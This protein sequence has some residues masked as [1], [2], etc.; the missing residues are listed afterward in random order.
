MLEV[1]P[2]VIQVAASGPDWPAIVA[3]ISTGV[4]AVAGI[5][6]ALWQA[7]HNWDHDDKRAKLSEKRRIYA[8]FLLTLNE[9]LRAAMEQKVTKGGRGSSEA[10][11]KYN[12]AHSRCRSALFELTLI[13]PAGVRDAAIYALSA[14]GKYSEDSAA[15]AKAVAELAN[16]MRVDLG[17]PP[18]SPIPMASN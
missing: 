4:A 10:Q 16:E 6:A 1:A 3:S 5:G 15:S 11:I 14:M 2:V 8:A 18:Y 9:V 17:E 7:N 13:A 12:E